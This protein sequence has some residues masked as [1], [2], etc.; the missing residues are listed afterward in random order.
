MMAKKI[1]QKVTKYNLPII[2]EP[3]E[4]GGYFAKCPV[5]QGCFVE[6]ETIP[7]A[8][9]YMEDAIKLFI[10]SYRELGDP[11]PEEIYRYEMEDTKVEVPVNLFLPV[12]LSV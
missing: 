8:I 12:A 2:I 10:E 1:H 4:E 9:E 3:C 11:L 7:Q 5:F 6:A